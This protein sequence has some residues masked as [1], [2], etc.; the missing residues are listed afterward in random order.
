MD[1]S[2]HPF[3]E[4]FTASRPPPRPFSRALSLPSLPRKSFYSYKRRATKYLV[5]GTWALPLPVMP[6]RILLHVY[7]ASFLLLVFLVSFLL[8]VFLVSFLLL[9]FLVSFLLLVFPLLFLLR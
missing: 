4:A 9:V 1:D 6:R 7:L 8:L 5:R 3:T 2:L